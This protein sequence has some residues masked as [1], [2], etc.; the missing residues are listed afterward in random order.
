VF[1]WY[2]RHNGLIILIPGVNFINFIRTNFLRTSFWQFFLRSYITRDKAVEITFVRKMLMKL[3]TGRKFHAGQ[4]TDCT[5]NVTLAHEG[6]D[7]DVQ[8]LMLSAQCLIRRRG[9]PSTRQR[10]GANFTNFR[11]TVH[12]S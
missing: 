8:Q 12:I 4:S 9:N 5:N 10:R 7:A 6:R 3:T 1:F 2:N 11:I